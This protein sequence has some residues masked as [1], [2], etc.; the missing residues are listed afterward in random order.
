MRAPDNISGT[1]GLSGKLWPVHIKPLEDELLSSW[2]VRL[3]RAHGL[4]LHT[5]CD[6][7]WRHKPIWNRDIDKSADEE[8]LRVLSEK[9]A[10]PIERVRQTTLAAYEGWLYEKHNP[11]GNTKWIMPVGV[12]HR[13]RKRPGLQ[14]CPMCLREDEDPY[15]RRRWRLAFVT[16]C[17]KHGRLLLD[18]CPRCKSPVNFHRN[19]IDKKSI[20]LCFRCGKDLREAPQPSDIR[21]RAQVGQ[22]VFLLKTLSDGWV[23]IPG[24]GPVY[25][26]FYFDVLHQLMRLLAGGE[27]SVPLRLVTSVSVRWKADEPRFTQND[28]EIETLGPRG[29]CILLSRGM[30]LLVD[31]PPRLVGVGRKHGIWS[32]ALL[33]DMDRPPFWYWRVIHEQ[34]YEPSYSPSDLEVEAAVS[35]TRKLGKVPRERIVSRLLGVNQVFRKKRARVVAPPRTAS[36]ERASDRPSIH[37]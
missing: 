13:M 8:I 31:W 14:Y 27:R 17:E 23:M 25:S 7:A 19:Q 16:L 24:S 15:F 6:L 12:Y 18:R 3:A 26:H 36:R 37:P 34:L 35:Y 33:R 10:T 9:T 4:R 21:V 22:Q 1:E 20:T 29:R 28:N 32:S 11:Y 5:F 30:W 2:L